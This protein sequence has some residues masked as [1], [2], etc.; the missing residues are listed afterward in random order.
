MTPPVILRRHTRHANLADIAGAVRVDVHAECAE[1]FDPHRL[2]NGVMEP[3]R[4]AGLTE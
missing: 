1:G 4:E 2:D 3:L